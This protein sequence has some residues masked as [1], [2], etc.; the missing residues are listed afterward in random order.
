MTNRALRLSLVAVIAVA[1]AS[2][3][4][5]MLAVES[6]R[7][8]AL[9]EP[10]SAT[11]VRP[12]HAL[13][14]TGA[15]E[16]RPGSGEP[17][18]VRTPGYPVFLGLAL[19]VHDSTIAVLMAQIAL[20]CATVALAGW[21]AAR[22][23]GPTA[24]L[25]AAAFLVVDPLQLVFSG[26]LLTETL[27]AALILTTVV[28]GYRALSP[29]ASWTWSLALGGVVACAA[30]VRPAM[31]YLPAVVVVLL[32]ARAARSRDSR[33]LGSVAAFLVPV[34][35]VVGGWQVRNHREVGSWRLSGIEAYILFHYRA[36]G[37]VARS[38]GV[39]LRDARRQLARTLQREHPGTFACEPD[40]SCGPAHPP[41]GRA[42]DTMYSAGFAVVLE[43]PGEAL[44]DGSAGL[45]S[46]TF[47]PGVRMIAE[48][49]GIR[50]SDAL[51]VLL[52]AWLLVFYL[53]A[54]IG[55]VSALRREPTR[56]LA[57]AFALATVAYVLLVSAGPEASSRVRVPVVPV[58]A[59]FAGLGVARIAA[60]RRHGAAAGATRSG[61]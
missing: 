38:E 27:E 17:E 39:R 8:G 42:F 19:A 49:L 25:A 35:V 10:D 4:G 55:A 26:K 16:T 5:W 57:H 32:A 61:S 47:N 11:Y 2:R 56:R 20:S 44:V 6:S 23:W 51:R 36:A 14:E 21:A 45:V 31:Y 12:G 37:A 22:L 9:R 30:L 33:L 60:R 41:V 54:G 24:G 50:D 53:C 43:H 1:A 29:H 28:L 58:L 13:A 40:G 46:E 18:Y 3:I 15:F 7:P 52:V 59:V 48:Y 34:V